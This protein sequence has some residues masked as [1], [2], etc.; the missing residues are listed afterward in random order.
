MILLLIPLRKTGEFS[1]ATNSVLVEIVKAFLV[2]D[3]I[4]LKNCGH[5]GFEGFQ[6]L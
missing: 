5:N 3:G 6:V 2:P 4:S 1:P